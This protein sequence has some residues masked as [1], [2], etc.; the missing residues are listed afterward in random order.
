VLAIGAVVMLGLIA[1][2]VSRLDWHDLGHA[3]THARPWWVVAALVLM[4]SSLVL[5]AISWHEVLRAAVPDA[6]IGWMPVVRATIV[7]V[8][9]SA[10]VPGRAGEPSRSMMVARRLGGTRRLFPLVLGTVVSQT[11]INL[12]ALAIL[13]AVTFTQVSLLHGHASGLALTIIVPVAIVVLVVTLPRMLRWLQHSSYDRVRRAAQWLGRQLASARQGLRVFKQ[14]RHGVPAVTAQ[15]IA[16]ALQWLACYCVLLALHLTPRATLVTAAAILLAVNVSAVLPAT[17]SN[18][19]VFQAACLVVLKAFGFGSTTG[20]AYG[21]M[22]QAV[23][24]VTAVAMGVPALLNEGLSWRD[25][26]S[27]DALERDEVAGEE[28]DDGPAGGRPTETAITDAG[29][30]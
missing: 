13:A 2:A 16:W 17:P 20:V 27:V 4:G 19:G 7:G 8:M 10:L 5:R 25:V 28:T 15:L 26:A 29:E 12:L 22:L 3:L 11:V 24:V 1:L 9:V 14:P 30:R 23:E 18:I 6:R 21:I